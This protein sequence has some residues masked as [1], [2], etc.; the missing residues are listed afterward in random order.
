MSEPTD[1]LTPTTRRYELDW[2]RVFGTLAVF[3]FHCNRIFD[4][5]GWH[6]K[7][8]EQSPVSSLFTDFTVQWLMP[9][10]FLVSGAST[11]FS[12]SAGETGRF[13]WAR[14]RRLVVPLV[15]G[16]F[17]LIP[18]QVYLE[19]LNHKEFAGSFLEFYPH[20]FD[21][22]YGFGGNFAWMGLHLW[23]LLALFL[24]SVI[25]LPLLL[26]VKRR[27]HT[28]FLAGL[29]SWAS[30]LLGLCLFPV[31]V[32]VLELL[33]DPRGL[34]L[35]DFGGWNLFAYLIFFVTGYL[36]ATDS[37]F[38][39]SIWRHR[40]LFLGLAVALLAMLLVLRRWEASVPVVG[41]VV[42]TARAF[43]SW[44]W[45]LA[46]LGFA[47]A[48]LTFSRPWLKRANEA[49]MPFYILHQTVILLV[50]YQ[51]LKWNAGIFGKFCVIATLAFATIVLLYELVIRR[52]NLLRFLF[53]MRIKTPE[54]G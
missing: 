24:F 10:F 43:H 48:H 36:L 19:R 9:L 45:L 12:L 25:S 38:Q 33:L 53:G 32:A 23:Y 29:G 51:I 46:M 11:W 3:F 18:P 27:V 16:I 22:F 4:H 37:R 5:G 6:V 40:Q 50:G 42:A 39:Q 1:K 15:F 54:P 13:L 34:G 14:V 47:L 52:V 17:V 28:V 44:F 20:Y 30:R 8:L 7:S 49:V 35:R 26:W 31:P 21:G 41:T 2:L